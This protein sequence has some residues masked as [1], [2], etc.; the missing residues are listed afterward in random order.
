[1]EVR[2]KVERPLRMFLSCKSNLR[3]LKYSF[4]FHTIAL[5][6]M[7]APTVE[8]ATLPATLTALIFKPDRGLPPSFLTLLVSA[9]PSRARP[10][11]PVF[12]RQLLGGGGRGAGSGEIVLGAGDTGW[13]D[14]VCFFWSNCFFH[15][16]FCF[17]IVFFP[18]TT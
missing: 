18:C 17:L 5:N 9:L 6:Y 2:L 7:G 3:T 1:M 16:N 4:A 15:L 14:T 11:F 8:F 13:F 12:T 10:R